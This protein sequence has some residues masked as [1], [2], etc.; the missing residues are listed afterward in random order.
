M[1]KWII[2]IIVISASLT[3]GFFI[4][5]KVAV[6]KET[7]DNTVISKPVYSQ[8]NNATSDLVK[9]E[10]VLMGS[11]FIFVIDAPE[12]L[13]L[14][15]ITQVTKRLIDLESKLSSWKPGSDVHLLNKHAGEYVKVSQDT[16]NLLL[17]SK[18]AYQN[19]NGD[20]DISIGSVWDL[21]PFRD[22]SAPMPTDE[23][24]KQQL[25][26]VGADKIKIN[27]TELKVKLPEGMKIN[28]GGIGKGYAAHLAITLMK[29]MAIKNAAVSAGGDVYLMGKKSTG[30]WNVRIENPRWQGKTIEKFS[31]AD[32]SVATSGD[33]KRFFIRNGKR[34]GHIINPENGKPATGVQSVTI[35]AEDATFADAYAT[36]VFVKGAEK[37][38]L[39]VNKR[40]VI[41]ALIIDDN[42]TV[43]R[44]AGWNALTRGMHL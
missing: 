11:Q 21:Y 38:M 27:K 31:V 5:D 34:Y 22:V 30:P 13:A 2:F 41:E 32:L 12:K 24:I 9:R 23:Q 18:Q 35:I 15:A 29:K 42:G 33:A 16:I 19:T 25:Q 26:F 43:F 1:K 44:S 7:V 14:D 36:A 6:K 10:V 20:F 4:R 39:W 37:G 17:L 40:D 28:L 8:D 3:Y